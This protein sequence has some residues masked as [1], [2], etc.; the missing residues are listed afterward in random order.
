MLGDK[1]I[2]PGEMCAGGGCVFSAFRRG[3]AERW[4]RLGVGHR[5]RLRR[6][7]ARRRGDFDER[8]RRVLN[9]AAGRRGGRPRPPGTQRIFAGRLL[10]LFVAVRPFYYG[11]KRAPGTRPSRM[12][13]ETGGGGLRR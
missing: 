10:G 9:V 13:F 8:R 7:A 3:P 11:D 1:T 5:E 6:A 2:F 12:R 4:V